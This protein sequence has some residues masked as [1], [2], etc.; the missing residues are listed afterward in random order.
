MIRKVLKMMV[1]T[2]AMAISVAHAEPVTDGGL[3]AANGGAPTVDAD[4]PKSGELGTVGAPKTVAP[5]VNILSG[6]ALMEQMLSGRGPLAPDSMPPSSIGHRYRA[7]KFTLI[8]PTGTVPR[9][10]VFFGV[11]TGDPESDVGFEMPEIDFNSASLGSA[12]SWSGKSRELNVRHGGKLLNGKDDWRELDRNGKHD[13][14]STKFG[15]RVRHEEV[16]DLTVRPNTCSPSVQE[17]NARLL[18]HEAE[19]LGGKLSAITQVLFN[20]FAQIGRFLACLL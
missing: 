6:P 20:E 16:A 15:R 18:A 11:N 5:T 17:Q 10:S 8:L 9:N 19:G 2:T 14:R 7:P 1:C 13:G 4:T 12:A 3:S